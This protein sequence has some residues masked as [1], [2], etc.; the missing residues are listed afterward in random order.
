MTPVPA[1]QGD[2]CEAAPN[3][4]A[5]PPKSRSILLHFNDPLEDGVNERAKRRTVSQ[6]DQGAE[7]QHHQ[8]HRR[9]PPFLALSHERPKFSQKDKVIL[10]IE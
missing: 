3:N 5:E 8:N 4:P 7:Q 1:D 9:Q 10:L 2:Q 6:E